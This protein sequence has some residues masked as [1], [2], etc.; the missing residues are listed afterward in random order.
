M[1]IRD[2]DFTFEQY[3]DLQFF[4]DDSGTGEKTEDATPR[5]I[6]KA[7]EKGDVA[8]STD[9]VTAIILFTSVAFFYWYGPY[10][11]RNLVEV[12]TYYLEFRHTDFTGNF[13]LFSY[14]LFMQF[15]TVLY[16]LLLTI[17]IAAILANVSQFGIIFTL[18]PLKPNVSKLNPISG[19]KKIFSLNSVNEL[20]KSIFKLLILAYIP[21]DVVSGRYSM[22]KNLVKVPLMIS[23]TAIFTMIFEIAIKISLVLVILAI[24]DFSYQKWQYNKKL[25]MSKYDIRQERKEMEGDPRQKAEQ[26]RRAMEMLM[27][28]MMAKVPDADVVIT[29]PTHIAVAVKYDKSIMSVPFVLAKGE[30]FIAQKIKEIAKENRIPVIEDKPLARMLFK[31]SEVGSP[32]PEE[33]YQSVAI[34]LAQIYKLQGRKDY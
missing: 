28:S 9:L 29:N 18:E 23:M 25:K 33:L 21:Y 22:L 19:M 1:I 2:M 16:P 7:R 20:I 24:I 12:V 8:K 26:R 10:F 17:C 6:R 15:M 34:V 30:G 27:K 31:T 4:A 11:L 14:T 3:F 13:G 32:I 5:K